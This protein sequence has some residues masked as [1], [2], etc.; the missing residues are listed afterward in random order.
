MINIED[1]NA[2]DVRLHCVHEL[3]RQLIPEVQESC[4][5]LIHHG[6]TCSA[7]SKGNL[8]DTFVDSEWRCVRWLVSTADSDLILSVID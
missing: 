1:T 6:T 7:S 2:Y 8:H 4:R 3:T 5:P